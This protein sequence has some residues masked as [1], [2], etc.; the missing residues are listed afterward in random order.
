MI[1]EQLSAASQLGI[2][3]QCRSVRFSEGE[4]LNQT[5][6]LRLTKHFLWKRNG[7][8]Y[9]E[10]ADRDGVDMLNQSCV[11]LERRARTFANRLLQLCFQV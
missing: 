11:S 8:E 1:V 2:C 5:G 10:D 6:V 3:Q 9:E 4:K 7:W